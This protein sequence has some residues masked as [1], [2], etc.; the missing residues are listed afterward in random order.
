ML[1]LFDFNPLKMPAFNIFTQRLAEPILAVKNPLP[2][3]FGDKPSV[4]HF[5]R[6]LK[7]VIVEF[8]QGNIYKFVSAFIALMVI[9]IVLVAYSRYEKNKP[10]SQGYYEKFEPQNAIRK[11]SSAQRSST[12]SLPSTNS[13]R[14]LKI[15]KDE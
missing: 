8:M 10:A 15:K 11:E 4:G 7:P 9:A 13:E 14:T 12:S 3:L 1:L 5:L 2:N 6:N